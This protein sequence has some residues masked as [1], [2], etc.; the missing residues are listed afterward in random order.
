MMQVWSCGGGTQS[1]AI[2][3]LIIQGMLPKPDLAV[4]VDTNREKQSTWDYFDS[5]LKPQLSAA[6][7]E[8]TVVD[9]S[10]YATVDLYP[11]TGKYVL[12]PMYTNQSGMVGKLSNYCSAEWKRDVISRWMREQGIKQATNWIGIS[13]DEMARVRTPRRAWLRLRYPLIFDVPMRRQDCINLVLSMGWP[14]PPRSSCWMCPNMR[15][16]EWRDMKTHYPDDFQ[17]AVQLERELRLRDQNLF[18]HESCKPLD[19][20]DFTQYQSG[21]F[22]NGCAS[23]YCFI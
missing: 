1:A 9:R 8:V 23:G 4:I 11:T 14:E 20:I 16:R 12:L 18:L 5:I 7:L 13:I 10:K 15:D 17:R 3:A 6:G 19:E 21:L 2:A 22:D